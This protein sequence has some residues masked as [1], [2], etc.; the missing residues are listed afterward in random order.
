MQEHKTFK[1]NLL[2]P[3]KDKSRLMKMEHLLSN[4]YVLAGV[5]GAVDL[6][7]FLG[8]NFV[9]HTFLS[10]PSLLLGKTEVEEIF[11]MKYLL[12]TSVSFTSFVVLLVLMMILDAVLIFRIK[13]SWSEDHFNVGQ[14]G[15]SRFLMEEEI[16]EEYKEIEP[17]ETRYPGNPGT[18]IS[19]IGNKFYIDDN[20]VNNL[21]LGL[22]R[23][24]K[25]EV[26]IKTNIEIY[27]RAQFLPSLVIN[28]PKLEHY[29]VF[30]KV[31]EERGYDVR[32]L[33]ASNPE[34]SMGFNLVTV[35]VEFYKKKEYDMA[36]MVANSIARSY[37]KAEEARGDMVYF[38][39]AATS[40][41]TA[42]IFASIEDAIVADEYENEERYQ[43]WSR[44]EE[45]ERKKHPFQYR[46]DNEK[47][48][49]VYSMIVNF[50]ELVTKPI[51]KDGSKTLLDKFY[52]DRPAF[53]RARLKYLGVQ[54]AP[55]KTK[56]GVFAEMLREL[57]IFTLHN[58]AKMTAES[59]IDLADI[60]F[61]KKPMA[62]FLAT[63]SYDSSLYKLPTIFIRQMYYVL[64]RL[65]DEGKGKCDRQVRVIFDEVGNMPE[66][67]LMKIMISMGLG[68]NISFD[69]A[70]QNYEQFTDVYGKEI[71]ETIK[72]NCANHYYLQTQSED[73][74]L[75]FS[76]KLGN[77][78]IIDVQR[79]GGKLSFNKYFS[80]SVQE[81]PLLNMNELMELM[82]GECA[83]VRVSKRKDLK[84]NKIKPRPIFNSVENGHYFWYAYEYFPKEKFPHPNEVNFLDICKESRSHIKPRER[85]WNLQKSWELLQK[86]K[87][88]LHT[89]ENVGFDSLVPLLEKSL[90]IHFKEKYGVTEES[91]VAE[92]VAL[93]QKTEMPEAE[94]ETLLGLLMH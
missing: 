26:L 59:S 33:N 54:V 71:A 62:I 66:I 64:G 18:L 41:F 52:E 49:N 67:E 6:I 10:I 39:N 24:G 76:K 69:L 5:I 60:G 50:G 78:S 63:P 92:T 1:N 3:L 2:T 25:G 38:T 36:E 47:T 45:E 91:T 43:K 20:L 82:E 81:R 28:D 30:R 22:T 70:V 61:G 17:L 13:V 75:E 23:S 86:R 73:T 42:M 56:S 74:A 8:I 88:K 7:L 40:L 65:C 93:I 29:K 68:Q 44:L 9:I 79:S 48:I 89:L 57:D 80:E 4:N 14:K 72:G 12:P 11:S 46:H 31:L 15:T 53:D 51:T 84:G 77:K 55:S 94:R 27:S 32:L 87:Y 58:V 85:I 90:G 21:F 19:R 35:A 16:K 37:F 34:L 83:I